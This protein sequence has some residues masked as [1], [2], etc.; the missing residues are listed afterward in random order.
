[1]PD[2]ILKFSSQLAPCDRSKKVDALLTPRIF[3]GY[4][5]TETDWNTFLRPQDLPE[6]AGSAG[7]AGTDGLVHYPLPSPPPFTLS[8]LSL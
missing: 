2:S 7:L 4:G 5:T 3:N 8:V 6:K 1:M